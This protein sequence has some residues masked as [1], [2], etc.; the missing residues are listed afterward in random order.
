[1]LRLVR[2]QAVHSR[3]SRGGDPARPRRP[4][5]RARREVTTVARSQ[6][7]QAAKSG[8]ATRAG[9]AR[10]TRAAAKTARPAAGER[11]PARPAPATGKAA[12]SPETPVRSAGMAPA[13]SRVMESR[14]KYV[15][16]IIRSNDLLRFGPIGIGA[17][18]ADVHT[19]NYKALAAVVSDTPVEVFD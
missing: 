17:E 3:R 19:V 5:G 13:R 10:S 14:G 8:K 7:K 15:Y 9:A 2:D 4:G 6:R 12:R 16:C 18:P 11:R 1:R